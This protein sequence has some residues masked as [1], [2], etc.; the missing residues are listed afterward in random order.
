MLNSNSENKKISII[1]VNF[2]SDQYLRECIASLYNFEKKE[3]FEIIIIN[4]EIEI[5]LQEVMVLYPEIKIINNDKNRGF[6]QAVNIG[7][8]KAC[9]EFI[10][11]L[12]PD[13]EFMESIFSTVKKEFLVDEKVAVISP[14]VSEKN[15]GKQKWLFGKRFSLL[16]LLKNNL[17]GD[18]EKDISQKKEVDWV[19]GASMFVRKKDFLL[20]S[21]FDENFFLYLEDMDLCLRLK[22]LD[23][24]I[25]Y[26]PEVK[27][28]HL[29]GGSGIEEEERKKQ[30]YISQDYYFKK[31]FGPFQASLVKIFRKI[32][33]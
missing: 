17:F 25:I 26:L 24:K 6:G 12:N 32:F 15:G 31:H 11:F 29:G 16:N 27:T 30:Y 22:K 21:G 14:R 28:R 9:G 13:T 7:V 8:E 33:K 19:S 4:N 5:D 1:I 23:K 20:A 10:L 2:R 18:P 3:G